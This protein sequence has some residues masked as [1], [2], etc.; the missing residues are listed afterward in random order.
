MHTDTLLRF[1]VFVVLFLA[2]ATMAH[3]VP[4]VEERKWSGTYNISQV[5]CI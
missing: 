3:A 1:S 5:F 2:T 4:I